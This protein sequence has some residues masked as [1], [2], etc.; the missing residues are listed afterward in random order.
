MLATPTA[1]KRTSWREQPG[2]HA[3]RRRRARPS[4]ARSCADRQ[5]PGGQRPAEPG[6]PAQVGE[7]G[8]DDVDPAVRVVDPVDRH[9]VDAQPGPLGQHQQ[10]GVE[11][12]AG[13]ARPCGSSR[14]ATSARIALKP[15]CA[16]EKP[17]GERAAQ[18][19]VVAAG[20]ELPLRPAH[21]P[22]AAREP[23]AD[24]EVGV[25]GQQRRDQRQQ[26]GQVGGQVD[27]HVGEHRRVGGG[28][29][30]AQRAA[31]ALLGQVHD[32]RP[33]RSSAAS[34]RGDRERARRCWRCRR[35]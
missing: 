1:A 17:G 19:Q 23:A 35:P 3:R 11:E 12:P 34:S 2:R 27:V 22:R 4:C 26:R 13:V 9:L 29:D 8:G 14:A 5:P 15:H 24:R 28:P 31:A 32:R 25:P 20:D 33:R 30:G 18:Q 7:R 10:L 16:S 21:H 6:D